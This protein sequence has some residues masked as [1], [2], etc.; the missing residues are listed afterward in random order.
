MEGRVGVRAWGETE[1]HNYG[2]ERNP[3]IGCH[4]HSLQPRL[5]IKSATQVHALYF[6]RNRTLKLLVPQLMLYLLRAMAMVKSLMFLSELIIVSVCRYLN[7]AS[8]RDHQRCG[9]YMI[10]QELVNI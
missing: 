9:Q 10:I 5:G 6:I 4:L 8:F 7:T 3:S 2:C 1:K